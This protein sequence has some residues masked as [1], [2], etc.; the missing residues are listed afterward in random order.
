VGTSLSW[1]LLSLC[2]DEAFSEVG[3]GLVGGSLPEAIAYWFCW[4]RG[5]TAR[6]RSATFTPSHSP[7]C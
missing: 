5:G 1:V 7:I 2:E 3:S 4:R 6:F